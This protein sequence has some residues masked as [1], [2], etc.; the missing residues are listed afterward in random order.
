MQTYLLSCHRLSSYDH[1]C[2][3][4]PLRYTREGLSFPMFEEG[5][6]TALTLT[7]RCDISED[8]SDFRASIEAESFTHHRRSSPSEGSASR[9]KTGHSPGGNS[10]SLAIILSKW[11]I[12]PPTPGLL[13][14][15]KPPPPN[16]SANNLHSLFLPLRP[17]HCL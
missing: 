9:V 14:I 3:C 2:M 6:G 17:R 15:S 11:S 10:L 1:I 4:T 8:E 16:G 7:M 12:P 13:M 5:F